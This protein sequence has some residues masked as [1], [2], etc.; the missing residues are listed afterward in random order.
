MI[1]SSL[2]LQEMEILKLNIPA[3]LTLGYTKVYIVWLRQ[4]HAY[5]FFNFKQIWEPARLIPTAW[6]WLFVPHVLLFLGQNDRN[7]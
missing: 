2:I 4:G 6:N 5:G 3:F 1:P 7:C